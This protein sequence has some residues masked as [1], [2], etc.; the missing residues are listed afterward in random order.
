MNTFKTGDE[1]LFEY[2]E[3][4]LQGRLVNTYPDHCIVETEKGSYTIGWNHVVDKA[5]VTSTFEQMGQELGAFVDKKQAAYGDSVSKASKLMKVFLEEY[6]NGDGTY[7]IPE[8][9]LDHILLQVRIIDKQNRIFS[10]PKGDLMDE[11]PYA[12]LAGYGLLGK[13][14]SGK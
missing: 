14:N 9:L 4:T 5:P 11:T 3:Q 10:N 1:I 6:E 2:G 12:D 7:T 8:E 13:R